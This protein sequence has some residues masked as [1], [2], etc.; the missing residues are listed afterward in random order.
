MTG[1][2]SLNAPVVPPVECSFIAAGL[3]LS[4]ATPI[5]TLH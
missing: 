2:D 3:V 4:L 5:A 1:Q